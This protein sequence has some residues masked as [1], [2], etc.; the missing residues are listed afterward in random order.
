MANTW[1]D[2]CHALGGVATR[3]PSGP[4][5]G[6]EACRVRENG[7]YVYKPAN[8]TLGESLSKL[9][10]AIGEAKAK[11][12]GSA[13]EAR[14]DVVKATGLDH[15]AL[16]VAGKLLGVPPIVVLA[17]AAGVVYLLLRK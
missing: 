11:A 2:R 17:G 5:M 1:Q 15:G 4:D 8:M 10:T 6:K 7:A 12:L 14:D 13:V 16:G 9:S 3:F